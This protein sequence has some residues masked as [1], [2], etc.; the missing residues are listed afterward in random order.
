MLLFIALLLLLPVVTQLPLLSILPSCV[1]KAF[2]ECVMRQ[3]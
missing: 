1:P 2:I 3:M